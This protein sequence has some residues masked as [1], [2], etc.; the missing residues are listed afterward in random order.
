[1][2]G[3]SSTQSR[4]MPPVPGKLWAGTLL[5]C[6]GFA[7]AGS[8][9]P[10][11]GQHP[12]GRLIAR[13]RLLASSPPPP[14]ALPLGMGAPRDGLLYVPPSVRGPAPLLVVLHAAGGDAKAALADWREA[15]DAAGLI[16]MLPESRGPSWDLVDDHFGADSAAIDA[17]L[18]R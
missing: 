7:C 9:R 11:P 6:A 18:A 5:A 8:S 14:G 12:S 17:A 13:P 3:G 10:Q 4:T 16:L 15:A 1:M 2:D